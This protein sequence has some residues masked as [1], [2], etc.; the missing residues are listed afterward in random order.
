MLRVVLYNPFSL[1][2]AFRLEEIAD[3]LGA[4]IVCLLGTQFKEWEGRCGAVRL[5]SGSFDL[6]VIVAYP[7]PRGTIAQGSPARARAE[8]AA[9]E[10]LRWVR[11]LLARWMS[12]RDMWFIDP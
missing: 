8:A 4:D 2:S 10:T 9:E 11:W 6:K 1:T 3:E 5:K 12:S 7:P